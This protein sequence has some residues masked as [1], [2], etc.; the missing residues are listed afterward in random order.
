[1]GLTE[2][3]SRPCGTYAVSS[4]E[5]PFET[6]WS[7]SD[8]DYGS[9]YRFDYKEQW[10]QHWEEQAKR[11]FAE[12]AENGWSGTAKDLGSV[13]GC[14]SEENCARCR[15]HRLPYGWTGDTSEE[16]SEES[17]EDDS[18]TDSNEELYEDDGMWAVWYGYE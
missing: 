9:S 11:N 15:F 16:S 5:D 6:R 13:K 2:I 14:G 1:M 3:F 18:A 17:S 7:D 12:F 4:E 8:E 10:A